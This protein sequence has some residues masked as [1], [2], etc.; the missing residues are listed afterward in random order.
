MPKTST[1]TRA[2]TPSRKR[3]A[4][5]KGTKKASSAA[6]EVKR[7]AMKVLAGAAA[8]AVG[9]IIPILE[10]AAGMGAKAV[11]SETAGGKRRGNAKG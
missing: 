11:D 2:A 4:G 7:T 1:S 10:K 8:G 6:T 3:T 5:G 9:A